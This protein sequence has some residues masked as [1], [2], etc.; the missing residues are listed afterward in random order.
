MKFEPGDVVEIALTSSQKYPSWAGLTIE[1][2]SYKIGFISGKV[3]K[4]ATPD[5]GYPIA[6]SIVWCVPEAFTHVQ[7]KL[8]EQPKKDKYLSPFSGCWE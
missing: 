2:S 6:A 5:R 1:V 4:T 3:L 8:K 7:A